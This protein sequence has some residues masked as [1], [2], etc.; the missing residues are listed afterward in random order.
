MV[1]SLLVYE[2]R[3]HHHPP[4]H[5]QPP[6]PP[7]K[8]LR[9][10]PHVHAAVRALKG[11]AREVLFHHNIALSVVAVA[12]AVLAE[13]LWWAGGDVG[14]GTA[15]GPQ[16][17]FRDFAR[18]AGA[19]SVLL[20]A[21]VLFSTYGVGGRLTTSG[22]SSGVPQ[23][24]PSPQGQGQQQPAAIAA[25]A[26]SSWRFWQPFLGGARFVLLQ[27]LSW[28]LFTCSVLVQLAFVVSTMAL[29]FE[30][31]VGAAAVAGV[32]FL[33]SEVLM[34]VSLHVYM[35]APPEVWEEGEAEAVVVAPPEERTEAEAAAVGKKAAKQPKRGGVA[36]RPVAVDEEG[37]EQLRRL[38]V[39]TILSNMQYTAFLL[40]IVPFLVSGLPP[41]E[42]VTH[43]GAF[44]CCLTSAVVAHAFAKQT[45]AKAPHLPT[46]GWARAALLHT[47]PILVYAAEAALA[48]AAWRDGGRAGPV[49]AALVATHFGYIA[50]T[51][52]GRPEVTGSR[53]LGEALELWR[54]GPSLYAL[55]DGV[56]G[57]FQA[58]LVWTGGKGSLDAIED[59]PHI[60]AFH[61]HGVQP[62]TVF[63]IQTSRAWRAAM[64]GK[65]FCVM[66]ASVCHAVPLL[67]DL[68]QW[69]G[70]REVSKESILHALGRGES[71]LLVP[72]GQQ[73]MIESRSGAGETRV[74]TKHVGFIR[75]A[76]QEGVPLVPVLSLGE[77]EVLDFVRLPS[78][79]R[80]FIKRIGIP[81][82]FLPYGARGNPIHVHAH[83]SPLTQ[84][85]HSPHP[86]PH[87][88]L[89]P[90]APAPR[91]HHRALRPPHRCG[92]APA[93]PHAG[94]GAG[95]G[96]RLLREPP[97]AL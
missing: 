54:G 9:M 88:A 48:V 45:V 76:M 52:R 66:T 40:P 3:Q 53:Y 55:L 2:R 7:S 35:P 6:G 58:R 82:P 95:G 89:W 43:W 56:E 41:A 16:G 77:V 26:A 69:L 24:P 10:L 73:E 19:L 61:P 60:L 31:F 81:V 62:F 29:G 94:G 20:F 11:A 5:A 51:F 36:L 4:A 32:F 44:F 67:R 28:T 85:H 12:T 49:W 59:R 83:R 79:Q 74:V 91:A 25:A 97:G 57:Y 47:P 18:A 84:P 65:R 70:G 90:P 39:I 14:A 92:R 13:A 72:G 27:A 42:A 1:T 75:L 71:V 86:H 63:W 37:L 15:M 23:R 68:L 30:L 21:A 33:A 80:F 64:P 17:H 50:T 8:P 38:T 96:G 87:R 93:Q 22:S 46:D 78:L 34:I